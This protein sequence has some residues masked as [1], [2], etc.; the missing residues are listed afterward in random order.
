MSCYTHFPQCNRLEEGKYLR[1]ACLSL[2]LSTYICIYIYIY[3]Y[4]CICIYTL[5]CNTISNNTLY[6]IILCNIIS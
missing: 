6:Y 2:S 5:Q 4:I 3:V 1:R